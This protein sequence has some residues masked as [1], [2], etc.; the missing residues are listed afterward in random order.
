MGLSSGMRGTDGAVDRVDCQAGTLAFHTIGDS[1]IKEV[2]GSGIVDFI[3]ALLK[4]N[5]LD[6]SGRLHKKNALLDYFAE[7]SQGC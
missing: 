5:H 1:R 4:S 7:R 6:T 2:C 3:V